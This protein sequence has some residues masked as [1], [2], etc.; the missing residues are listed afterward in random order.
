MPLKRFFSFCLMCLILPSANAATTQ[1][2]SLDIV[3]QAKSGDIL[4]IDVRTEDEY[5]AGH[6]PGA[7]NIPHD[8][9]AQKLSE[10]S[11]F[12]DK[13]VVVYCRSGYRA[14]KAMKVL[15][16]NAFSD[17]RHLEGDMLGWRKAALPEEK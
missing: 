8:I 9:I 7:I 10:I 1:Q 15:A 11:A 3:D 16:N 17:I 6:V 14:T 2:A 12:K 13:P 5:K 4:I